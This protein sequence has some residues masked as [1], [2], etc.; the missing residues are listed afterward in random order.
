M[1]NRRFYHNSSLRYPL[2]CC[3]VLMALLIASACAATAP[4]MVP[5]PP[6]IAARPRRDLA[7]V[8][9]CLTGKDPFDT[10]CASDA[11]TV[12]LAHIVTENGQVIGIVELRISP[13][14]GTGW[15]RVLRLDHTRYGEAF[16]GITIDGGTHWLTHQAKGAVSLWTDM[17]YIPTNSCVA[18][19]ALLYDATG[20]AAADETWA[21]DC[22]QRRASVALR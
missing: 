13:A 19:S 4:P 17:Q 9:D 11:R 8:G 18:A 12:K 22:R 1:R 16:G 7:C 20:I 14:C 6:A 15:A 21:S 2:Q 3:T 5:S 10:G